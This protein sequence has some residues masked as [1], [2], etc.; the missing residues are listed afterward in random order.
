[1]NYSSIQ[2][3]LFGKRAFESARVNERYIIQKNNERFS[4]FFC[5]FKSV[6]ITYWF[7]EQ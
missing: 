6:T 4:T 2:S 3:I 7:I 1:M 5:L